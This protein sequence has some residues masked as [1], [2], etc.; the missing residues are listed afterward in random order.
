MEYTLCDISAFRYHRIPPQVVML[1]PPVPRPDTDKRRRELA[2]HP[3]VKDAL[4]LPLHLLS[5]SRQ[6]RSRSTFATPHVI[7]GELP[8]GSVQS[9]PSE[10]G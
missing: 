2:E 3:L 4:G 6:T 10:L 8:A 5:D 1:C 9:S 7:S